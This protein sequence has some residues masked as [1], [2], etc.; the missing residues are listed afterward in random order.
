MKNKYTHI[1]YRGDIKLTDF[2]GF[3]IE[4]LKINELI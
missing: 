4:K 2:K 3:I 1:G